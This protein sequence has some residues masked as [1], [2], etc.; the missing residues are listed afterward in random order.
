MPRKARYR[1][2]NYLAIERTN[3]GQEK[4]INYKFKSVNLQKE[5]QI[6]LVY[7]WFQQEWSVICINSLL[8]MSQSGRVSLSVSRYAPGILITW[9]SSAASRSSP[10]GPDLGVEVSLQRGGHIRVGHITQEAVGLEG[11]GVA[12]AAAGAKE[13]KEAIG[14]RSKVSVVLVSRDLA[15]A[16][17]SGIGTL[18]FSYYPWWI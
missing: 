5:I 1:T 9:S 2:A 7:D 17:E 6:G 10:V 13:R 18:F 4:R 12:P 15:R 8:I 16:W 3:F 14:V 11:G